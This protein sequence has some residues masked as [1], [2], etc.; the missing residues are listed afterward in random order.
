MFLEPT[1]RPKLLEGAQLKPSRKCVF[2][3]FVYTNVN[4]M[5]LQVSFGATSPLLGSVFYQYTFRASPSTFSFVKAQVA[6]IKYHGWSRVAIIHEFDNTFFSPVSTQLH[7]QA[8]CESIQATTTSAV[9]VRYLRPQTITDR[10]L[11]FPVRWRVK[12]S[13]QGSQRNNPDCGGVFSWQFGNAQ[14]SNGEH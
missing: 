3:W 6:I 7:G 5:S 13:T 1:S 11:H 8:P 10:F 12:E 9:G 4:G 2:R 14:L